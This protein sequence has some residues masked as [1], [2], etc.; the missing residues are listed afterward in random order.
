MADLGNSLLL[1]VLVIL[2]T[3]ILALP[4]A[5]IRTKTTLQKYDWLDIVL[6]IPFMTPPYIGSMGWILFMQ[7]NGFLQQLVPGTAWLSDAFFFIWHGHG[8]EST[9]ISF[10]ILNAEKYVA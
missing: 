9:S 1:G 8:Y 2:G 3:T 10:S 4:M 6:T 7:N 5:F